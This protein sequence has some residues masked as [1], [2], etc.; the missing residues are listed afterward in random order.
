MII[1]EKIIGKIVEI[2]GLAGKAILEVYEKDFSVDY[3]DDQ[4]P[5]TEADRR[6]HDII[7]EGLQALPDVLPVLSEEG[8]Q[9]SLEERQGWEE[10]WLIDPLDGTKEFVG[11]NGEFTVNIALLRRVDS[12]KGAVWLPTFGLVYVPVNDEAYLGWVYDADDIDTILPGQAYK[13]K[14]LLNVGAY[15]REDARPLHPISRIERGNL[16]LRVVASRSHCTEETELFMQK[17]KDDIGEIETVHLGSCLKMCKIASGYA[18]VYPRFAPTMEWDTSA[19][20]AVCRAVGVSVVD[21][22]HCRPLTYNKDNLKNPGIL[23][24]GIQA[25]KDFLCDRTI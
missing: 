6:A 3:K 16:P 17:I 10:Y 11:K 8:E 19:A 14:N 1:N 15:W 4:S 24:T 2:A 12:A 13:L 9:P 22:D 23:V 5:I 20:H 18:H 7:L 21:V 25:F